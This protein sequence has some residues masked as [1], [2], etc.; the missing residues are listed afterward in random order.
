MQANLLKYWREM[1]GNH[2]ATRN[3]KTAIA[4]KAPVP[5]N[6]GILTQARFPPPELIIGMNLQM[7]NSIV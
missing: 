5:G 4:H 6:I 7:S 2:V 1:V 3:L